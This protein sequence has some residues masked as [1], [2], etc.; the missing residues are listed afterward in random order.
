MSP[1]FSRVSVLALLFLNVSTSLAIS[2]Y[3]A[4]Y[5]LQAVGT[6]CDT[7]ISLY[8]DPATNFGLVSCFF[9]LL[10]SFFFLSSFF[11]LFPSIFFLLSSLFFL[12]SSLFLFLL[13]SSFFSLLSSFFNFSSL[14][15][16]CS[17][18][19]FFL[20]SFW[21]AN[22]VLSECYWCE[23]WYRLSFQPNRR[24]FLFV[25]DVVP[26]LCWKGRWDIPGTI[27]YGSGLDSTMW[28]YHE[29]N[30]QTVPPSYDFLVTYICPEQV[31]VSEEI[32]LS[33]TYISSSPTFVWFPPYL[34]TFTD[35]Q[36]RFCSRAVRT[37]MDSVVF[38]SFFTANI[39]SHRRRIHLQSA[40][41][42]V[43]GIMLWLIQVSVVSWICAMATSARRTS[44]F[45]H[46]KMML[47]KWHTQW[48]GTVS[49][50]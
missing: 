8:L 35:H 48:C 25:A 47:W 43:Q 12:L 15:F 26:P 32:V 28:I 45:S 7:Q 1:H 44:A 40:V 33:F 30:L 50:E 5:T 34:L 9:I 22:F 16:L 39:L 18:F 11:S 42:C 4:N 19:F 27:Q 23:C 14:F 3:R 2:N 37:G 41:A 21:S 36:T 13:S 10:S 46:V 6:D 38:W 49:C 29:A 17:F 24:S 31:S 20:S